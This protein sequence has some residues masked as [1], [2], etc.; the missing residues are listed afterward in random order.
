MTISSDTQLPSD[1][2]SH[3]PL[4]RIL[5]F[6][7]AS[8][9]MLNCNVVNADKKRL[10]ISTDIAPIHSL[11]LQVVGDIMQVD[12]IVPSSQSPH[13]FT[14]KPSQIRAIYQSDLIVIVSEAFSPS[15]S[16]HLKSLRPETTLLDLAQ[17]LSQESPGDNNELK[18]QSDD[19][20]ILDEHTDRRT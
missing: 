13:H 18:T 8:I 17:V 1:K 16:R 4:I 9:V 19:H 7:L 15:L 12:L 11:V 3:A 10:R 5:S 2:R 6:V 20:P 14:L